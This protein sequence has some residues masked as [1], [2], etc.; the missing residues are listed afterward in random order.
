MVARITSQYDRGHNYYNFGKGSTD[1]K[2]LAKGKSFLII[3]SR[4]I[5]MVELVCFPVFDLTVSTA[6]VLGVRFATASKTR[7]IQQT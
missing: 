7:E 4:F 6:V 1:F 5:L 2:A 3:V